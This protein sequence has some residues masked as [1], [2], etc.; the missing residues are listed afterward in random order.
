[1]DFDLF[2]PRPLQRNR[3]KASSN[4]H[5]KIRSRNNQVPCLLIDSL[6]SHCIKFSFSVLS[7]HEMKSDNW[8]EKN[9]AEKEETVEESK[10]FGTNSSH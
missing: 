7:G 8:E 10:Q 4:G 9:Q 5:R 1:M 2:F 3:A 6:T